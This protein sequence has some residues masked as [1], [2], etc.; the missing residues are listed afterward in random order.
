MIL[1]IQDDEALDSFVSRNRFILR[2]EIHNEEPFKLA[3]R[4]FW[5]KSDII[6]VASALGWTGCYGF[7]KLLHL[8]TSYFKTAVLVSR[9]GRAYSGTSYGSGDDCH[10]DVYIQGEKISLCIECVKSDLEK[11]GYS[12]WR[13]THQRWCNVCAVHNVLLVQDC[14]F[15]KKSFSL[16]N[17]SSYILWNG[18]SCGK[19]IL[20]NESVENR[21]AFEFKKAKLYL[22]FLNHGFHVTSCIAH[23]AI[24]RRL[25]ADGCDKPRWRNQIGDRYKETAPEMAERFKSVSLDWWLQGRRVLEFNEWIF[26]DMILMVFSSF[27]DFL[28][29]IGYQS[30]YLPPVEATWAS[31][32]IGSKYDEKPVFVEESIACGPGVA[33][34]F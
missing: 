16:K 8:H 29:F 22:D 5:R 10:L 17:H 19:S 4:N 28:D 6:S 21:N 25:I 33:G 15:C 26:V 14:Q 7:N 11:N 23:E 9:A 31:Y 24:I 32:Q 2:Q 12:Y 18:C 3:N 13:R 27:K 30:M 20:E 1:K 34:I